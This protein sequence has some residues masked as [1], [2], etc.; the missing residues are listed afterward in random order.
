MS[1]GSRFKLMKKKYIILLT[2]IIGAFVGNLEAAMPN[3]AVNVM[4]NI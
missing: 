3:T 2:V 1:K 4:A